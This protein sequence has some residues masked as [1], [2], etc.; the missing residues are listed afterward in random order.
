MFCYG[1][2]QCLSVYLNIR[3]SLLNIYIS[4]MTQDDYE[5][6]VGSYPLC[7]FCV[8]KRRENDVSLPSNTLYQSYDMELTITRVSGCLVS[9]WFVEL[10]HHLP[11]IK[12]SKP[13]NWGTGKIHVFFLVK[14]YQ[15]NNNTPKTIILVEP[16]CSR[17]RGIATRMK[18]IQGRLTHRRCLL[19][20]HNTP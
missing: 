8:S 19:E 13:W 2:I 17:Q 20:I 12:P 9:S 4:S 14:I 16:C 10:R 15:D 1:L 11:Y 5:L 18:S 3:H 7:L 6:L